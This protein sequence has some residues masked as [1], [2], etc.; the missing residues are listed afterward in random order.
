MRYKLVAPI[1]GN[2]FAEANTTVECD[3]LLIEFLV[4]NAK[5]L[6]TIAISIKVPPDRITNFTGSIGPGRNGAVMTIKIGGDKELHDRLI[7]ELQT[8][9]SHL[10]FVTDNALK[11]IRWDR[12]IK[13]DVIP[14]NEEEKKLLP[15]IKVSEKKEYSTR[16]DKFSTVDLI[17]FVKVFR[18]YEP[19][20]VSIAFWRE[21]INY[22][23]DFQY[24]LA[25]YFSYFVLEDLYGNGKSSE[26]NILKEFRKSPEFTKFTTATLYNISKEERHWANLVR[27]LQEEKCEQTAEGLQKLLVRI[28]GRL[29]HYYSGSSKKI[30]TPF[31]QSEY[32]TIAFITLSIASSAIAYNYPLLNTKATSHNS[33]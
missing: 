25:F 23:E 27:F 20:K 12:L 1:E 15:V 28:R 33:G 18:R 17:K 30:G 10:A 32:E 2:V 13:E 11:R 24:I 21:G 4:D 22:F 8:L 3:D 5:M 6:S 16:I 7:N 9:E 29:H 31:N 26:T 19:L 14:E